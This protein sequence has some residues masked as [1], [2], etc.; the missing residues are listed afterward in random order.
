MKGFYAALSTEILKA[1]RSKMLWISMLLFIFMGLMIG[2]LMSISKHPEIAGKSVV[3]N[4]KA[5]LI[6]KADW[7]TY[8]NLLIQMVLT[9]GSIGSGIVTIWVF[10][11][12]YTDR[13]V[14]DLLALPVSR[15]VFVMSKFIIIV[16]WSIMLL[17]LLFVTALFAGLIVNLDSWSPSVIKNYF[18]VYIVS[19]FLTV[20]LCSPVALITCLS[21]GYLLP[22]A[23]VFLTLIMTQFIYAAIPAII[24]YFPW[25]I[26][27]L[28]SGVAGSD[29]PHPG[30]ISYSV[31]IIT[32]GAGFLGTAAWWHFADQR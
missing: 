8:L 18:I 27:A 14:K 5:S 13:V 7:P 32:S 16:V 22:I 10:G 6:G 30:I 26:P 28:F 24:T 31:L 4:T 1:R 11:R 29:M 9:I 2:L 20:L 19:A 12:E 25:A 23:F 15:K 3:I 17:L 21:R